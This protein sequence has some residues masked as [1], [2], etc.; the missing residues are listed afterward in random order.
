MGIAIQAEGL[1][2]RYGEN[3]ALRGVDLSVPTG[4]VLGVLGPNGAGKTTTVRILATLLSADAGH[5][6][7][8]GFDV[9]GRAREVRRRIGLTGQ[10]AAVDER[11]TGREN[12]RLVGTLYHLGRRTAKR[13]ADD[14]LERFDL[15][16]AADRAVKG[17]S[18]GMRRRLDLAAS[19]VAR[20]EV[21]FLDEPTTGLDPHSRNTLWETIRGEVAAGVTVLLTTQ[22]L[23]EADQLADRILVIDSGSVI[24][25]GTADE[26]KRKV[27][28]ERLAVRLTTPESAERAARALTGIGTAPATLDDDGLTV[29]VAMAPGI[30][31]VAEAAGAL[32]SL[33][34]DVDDFGV[35]RPSLDDVF[36]SLTGKNTQVETG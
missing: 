9:A 11:L 33:G 1:R 21:L 13:V 26:L 5:A 15:T 34:L 36:L 30:G 18:G 12:L 16:E 20:P 29:T 2:K 25:E 4:T 24:A 10:Y 7:V 23:E 35:R 19:L 6:S 27:G 17:Y 22:Y 31:A 28:G 32:D 8:A 3:E 14:L